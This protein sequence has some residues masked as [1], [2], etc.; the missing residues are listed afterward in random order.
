MPETVR[1]IFHVIT[2]VLIAA[3]FMPCNL[4]AQSARR[5]ERRADAAF[6]AND[7]YTAAKLYSAILYDSP[8]AAL[9]PSVL[10]PFQ[11]F[12]RGHVGK[13]RKSRRNEAIYKLAESY[14]LYNHFKEAQVQYEQFLSLQDARFPLAG[15]GYGL[16][17][18][19]NNEPQKAITA[20]N[21]FLRNYKTKDG[22]SEKARQGVASANFIIAS[23]SQ[24]PASVISKL[25]ATVSADGSDFALE[26]INDSI[27]WFTT[28]RHELDKKNEKIY[29][30]RLYAGNLNSNTTAKITALA[31]DLNMA[32]PSLSGNGLT[33]YFTG[34]K[35]NS[36]I[37]TPVYTIFSMSRN[38]LDSPW[39]TPV[40]LPAPVNISGFHSKQPFISRDGKYLLFSSNQP[41]GL[42][43]YDIWIVAMQ[44]NTPLGKPFNP[45]E[46]VNTSADEV[47]PFYNPDSARLYFSSNGRV[48]MGGFDI[49][50]SAGNPLHNQWTAAANLGAPLNSV[51]DDQYYRTEIASAT[52]YLSSDRAS[53]CC[54]EIFKAVNVKY[55]DTVKKDT[56]LR[57]LSIAQKKL[58][59]ISPSETDEERTNKRLLDSLNAITIE[60]HYVHYD[61]AS[62][63]IRKQDHAP[64]DNVI[65]QLK[66]NSALNII[67]ASFTDCIGTL[68]RNILWARR[69]SESIREYLVKNGIDPS[70]INIDFFGKKHFILPCREGR[71]Y[72]RQEQV[73]NRR[74][75]LILTKEQK[76]K[77]RPA[78]NELDIDQSEL[79]PLYRSVN[80][81]FDQR[82]LIANSGLEKKSAGSKNGEP[83]TNKPFSQPVRNIPGNY[84][85]GKATLRNSR[86]DNVATTGRS[87]YSRTAQDKKQDETKTVV[88]MEKA[89]TQPREMAIELS[90][91]T[92]ADTRMY[93]LPVNTVLDFTPRVKTRVVTEMTKRIPRNPLVIYT[94]SDSVRIELYDN[95]VF[96][97]DT[98]SVIYNKQLVS[99]KQLLQTNKPISFFV[100]LSTNPANNEMILFAENLGLTPPN[101]ALMVITDGENKRTEVN[102]TSDL[103]HNTVIYFIK[104]KKEK[105]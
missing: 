97:F 74:S 3:F 66:E 47:T 20:L 44:G 68:S 85:D 65:R 52:A 8:L 11:T 19:A 50:Q 102:V 89:K 98:V 26:K 76:P 54:L 22:Y 13:I 99:Y 15:L 17:L 30:V 46:A 34:W 41:G 35:E 45:G 18:I 94:T 12:N 29:P 83:A 69:R 37:A 33:V 79:G 72:N 7:F 95:G 10:Y 1:K 27:F 24:Q 100:K 93:K 25:A 43:Q 21:S 5:L 82:S 9:A 14:R 75:D 84:N 58:P 63:R 36:K 40:A 59:V 96:D 81:N 77:W 4:H 6:T 70:R 39:K 105:Q 32:T 86:L 23:R 80:T 2:A 48:G 67:V 55:I 62:A 49:Y 104:V 53:S 73:A 31:G 56:S 88:A 16:S 42:G 87:A 51:R 78:G 90:K 71:S 28:S 60:R 92:G 61:F 91:M 103:E 101:S 64:L 57:S 38:A